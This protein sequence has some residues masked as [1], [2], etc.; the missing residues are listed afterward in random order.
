MSNLIR[1]LVERAAAVAVQRIVR[2]L[3]IIASLSKRIAGLKRPSHVSQNPYL[4]L[5]KN[6]DDRHDTDRTRLYRPKEELGQRGD[7]AC[8]QPH[9]NMGKRASCRH[10]PNKEHAAGQDVGRVGAVEAAKRN[11]RAGQVATLWLGPLTAYL[12]LTEACQRLNP[13]TVGEVLRLSAIVF[14]LSM[15][16]SILA[17]SAWTILALVWNHCS[18]TMWSNVQSSGTRDQRT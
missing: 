6:Y 13:R 10:A 2:P 7:A 4:V 14:L 1:L 12:M 11:I 17:V 9:N 15:L 18:W 5:P 8:C 3:H 16:I